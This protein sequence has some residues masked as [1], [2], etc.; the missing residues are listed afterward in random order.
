MMPTLMPNVD[1]QCSLITIF[2][3]ANDSA[4]NEEPS[5]HV[6]LT[7]F[8]DNIKAII[9]HCR[10]MNPSAVIVLVTPATV[11]N[12]RWPDRSEM[13]VAQYAQAIRSIVFDQGTGNSVPLYLLD[14][15]VSDAISMKVNFADLYD[16]LHFDNSGNKKMFKKLQAL[17]RESCPHVCPD[18]GN[19]MLAKHFPLWSV[20]AGQPVSET[21]ELLTNWRW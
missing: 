13:A 3:G 4:V 21:K 12:K 5:Q 9:E 10:V 17:I 6:P 20:L 8:I 11:D 7:E 16:G 18:D 14:L 2:L 15:W 1:V 19:P